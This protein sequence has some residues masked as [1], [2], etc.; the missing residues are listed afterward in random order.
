MHYSTHPGTP[1][2]LDALGDRIAVGRSGRRVHSNSGQPTDDSPPTNP[3][4]QL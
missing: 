2:T 1:A 3:S 4:Y